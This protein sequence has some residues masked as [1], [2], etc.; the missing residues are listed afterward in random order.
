LVLLKGES[1]LGNKNVL[2]R[3]GSLAQKK[4]NFVKI[5]K[6]NKEEIGFMKR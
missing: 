1:E 3:S 6:F 2:L 5:Y 4:I